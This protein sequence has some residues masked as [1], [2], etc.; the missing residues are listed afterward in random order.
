MQEVQRSV[1]GV[2]D[3]SVP[4][5]LFGEPGTGKEMIGREIHR[6]SPWRSAPFITFSSADPI[7]LLSK[8][9]LGESRPLLP[10]ERSLSS[11]GRYTLFIREVSKLASPLQA[12]LL[13]VFRDLSSIEEDRQRC[14]AERVRLICS[15]SSN[16]EQLVTSGS[17]RQDLFYRINV[18]T[19]SLPALR[20]RKEDIADLTE[21]LFE[22][23][24]RERNCSC[25]SP[26]KDLLRLF[27][28]YDW[29]GNIRELKDC[30]R[31]FVYT[32]GN[33]ALAEAFIS[34][35]SRPSAHGKPDVALVGS[36]S[37]PL[38]TFTRQLV[39]QAERD[40]ILRVLREQRWSRK[41]TAKILQ[42]S[43]QTLLHKLKQ[44]GLTRKR[45]T[46]PDVVD[47]PVRE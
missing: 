9:R 11:D 26:P 8:G 6:L 23:C 1:R 12:K 25:P 14:H 40:L 4:V 31:I 42:V 30:V 35:Q 32:G 29:P 36:G 16:L 34:R 2:A 17:F 41:E 37:M 15:S 20:D 13:E 7:N 22:L 24:R 39:E 28:R 5:L 43:Y 45:R 3:A 18:V 21:Y 38:K 44:T 10:S 33:A 46:Q 47:Q 19:I 27:S